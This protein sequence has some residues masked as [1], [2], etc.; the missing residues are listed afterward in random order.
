MAKQIPN[1][2]FPH[3]SN[4]PSSKLRLCFCASIRNIGAADPKRIID[5]ASDNVRSTVKQPFQ[6]C[7]RPAEP[8]E[9]SLLLHGNTRTTLIDVVV[10]CCPLSFIPWLSTHSVS[11]WIVVGALVVTRAIMSWKAG[12]SRYLPA[13]RFFACP[14]SP[15]SNGVRYVVSV[16]VRTVIPCCKYWEAVSLMLRSYFLSLSALL[17]ACV[18][19]SRCCTG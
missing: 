8:Q 12:L 14:E 9:L 13:M 18:Y 6:G 5:R 11:S 4:R 17:P 15:S 1:A 16:Q 10:C 7:C 2:S 19:E 3:S